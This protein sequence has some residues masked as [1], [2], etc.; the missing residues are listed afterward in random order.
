MLCCARGSDTQQRTRTYD[1]FCCVAVAV[2][3]YSVQKRSIKKKENEGS[4]LLYK[5]LEDMLALANSV[6]LLALSSGM[7]ERKTTAQHDRT[8]L[9]CAVELAKLSGAGVLVLCFQL[10][11]CDL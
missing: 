11:G 9:R 10:A 2:Y 5:M 1:C 6:C 7:Y 4:T 8:A 3:R